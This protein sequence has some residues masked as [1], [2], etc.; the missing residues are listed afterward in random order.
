MAATGQRSKLICAVTWVL[1]PPLSLTLEYR[2]PWSWIAS[3]R[4][5]HYLIGSGLFAYEPG[6]E[7]PEFNIMDSSGM[8]LVYNFA[9]SYKE[10]Q[11]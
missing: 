1:F 2:I 4:F 9:F 5:R 11:F 7:E 6:Q 3:P 10:F 8:D